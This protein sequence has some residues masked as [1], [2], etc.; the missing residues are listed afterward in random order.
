[1]KVSTSF[2][3]SSIFTGIFGLIFVSDPCYAL[4]SSKPIDLRASLPEI[5]AQGDAPWCST[6]AAKTLIEHQII[7]HHGKNN[8]PTPILSAIDIEATGKE[9]EKKHSKEEI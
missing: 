8:L 5:E 6:F 7:K 1:M 2:R 4:C 9:W 3:I